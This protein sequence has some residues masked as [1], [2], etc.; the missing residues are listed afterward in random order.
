MPITIFTVTS[1]VS[2]VCMF[3]ANSAVSRGTGYVIQIR[4]IIFAKRSIIFKIEKRSL[5]EFFIFFQFESEAANGKFFVFANKF[6]FTQTEILE[7]LPSSLCL[8]PRV[9]ELLICPSSC[10]G[11]RQ[12]G[13]C[14][15][16]A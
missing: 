11:S 9:C 8:N 6:M 10:D 13:G 15:D 2:S 4:V 14:V 16:V 5:F 7:K 3:A 1:L 12:S